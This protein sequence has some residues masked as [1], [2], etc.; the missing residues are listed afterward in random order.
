MKHYIITGTSKGIGKALAEEVLT[1]EENKVTGISRSNSISHERFKFMKLDL[2]DLD[3][4]SDFQL[5][6]AEGADEVILVN[7]AGY[8]GDIKR[9]GA[10]DHDALIRVFNVNV[11]APAVLMN[12]LLAADYMPHAAKTILNVSSGA[13]SYEIPAWASYCGSKTAIDHLSKTI[14]AEIEETGINARILSVGPGVVD[15]DMQGEIRGSNPEDF[16]RQPDFVGLKKNDQLASP[17][18]T[19]KKYLHILKTGIFD[20]EVK[21]SL[22]DVEL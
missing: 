8:L 13:G 20:D 3:A 15:T 14:K 19:A 18:E 21:G 5:P 11:S 16:S 1:D 17:K 9:Y 2:N 6:D 22:R 7:N 4:V 12:K 10:A